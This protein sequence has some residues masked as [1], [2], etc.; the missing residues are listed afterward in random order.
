MI[1][2]SFSLAFFA[3]LRVGELVSASR[4]K[5]GGLLSSDVI[6]SAD[7]VQL[8]I[9]RSKTDPFGKGVWIRLARSGGPACPVRTVE[10]YI[11]LRSLGVTFLSHADGSPLTRYQFSSVFKQCRL[12]VG[13]DPG[14]YGTHSFRIGAATEAARAGMADADIQ[15]LGRW[16]SACFNSYIRP[17]LI[18]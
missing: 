4:L 14:E 15:R 16:K 12:A 17:G 13:E 8:N 10:R 11:S 1:A 7:A 18:N 9:R 6:G 3:A 2:V 5:I